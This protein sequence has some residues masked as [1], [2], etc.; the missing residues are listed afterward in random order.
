MLHLFAAAACHMVTSFPFEQFLNLAPDQRHTQVTEPLLAAANSRRL[1]RKKH[2]KARIGICRL[3]S[4][5]LITFSNNLKFSGTSVL[6][7][8]AHAFDAR[9]DSQ[10]LSPYLE[11]GEFWGIVKKA[12]TSIK[13]GRLYM[14]W[15]VFLHLSDCYEPD[16]TPGKVPLPQ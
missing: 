6:G 9:L 5:G 2:G 12:V 10:I 14:L 1:S 13:N 15:S 3:S 11:F 16:I 4:V 7:K 8:K